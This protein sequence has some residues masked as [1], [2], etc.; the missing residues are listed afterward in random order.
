MRLALGGGRRNRPREGRA[1]PMRRDWQSA[2]RD[3]KGMGWGARNAAGK[4]E[5][6]DAGREGMRYGERHA[7]GVAVA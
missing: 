1:A 3:R 4:V 5:K 7:V 6:C 2:M